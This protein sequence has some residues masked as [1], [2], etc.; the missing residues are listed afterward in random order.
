MSYLVATGL[1]F[2]RNTT[3]DLSLPKYVTITPNV[4]TDEQKRDKHF[5]NHAYEY[6]TIYGDE[7][8]GY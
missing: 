7:S 1:S 2:F 5:I 3:V 4:S 6:V 8:E